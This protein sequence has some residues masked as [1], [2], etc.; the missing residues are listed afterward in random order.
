MFYSEGRVN[1]RDGIIEN[2]KIEEVVFN[3]SYI[4]VKDS[5]TWKGSG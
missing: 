1:L 5:A 3:Y 2:G 4:S